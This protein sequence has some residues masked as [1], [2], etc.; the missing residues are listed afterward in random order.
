MGLQFNYQYTKYSLL[1]SQTAS[2]SLTGLISF[3]PQH[4]WLYTSVA[5]GLQREEELARGRQHSYLDNGKGLDFD[6]EARE[7]LEVDLITLDFD[8]E[9]SD[10]L[11]I[12]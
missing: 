6:A 8:N 11:T 10:N 7:K 4:M 9:K 1:Q 12:S 5:P 3:P 2:T